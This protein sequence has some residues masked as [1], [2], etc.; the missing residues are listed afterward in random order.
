M[1]DFGEF[2]R[3]V[4]LG[5]RMTR[6]TIHHRAA[7]FYHAKVCRAPSIP[8]VGLQ[9]EGEQAGTVDYIDW[10][11]LFAPNYVHERCQPLGWVSM[12]RKQREGDL[13]TPR[14]T[15]NADPGAALTSQVGGIRA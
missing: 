11:K 14:E 2:T 6:M 4:F 8:H 9:P 5:L 3:C 10:L 7:I 13:I 15:S 12:R 1:L